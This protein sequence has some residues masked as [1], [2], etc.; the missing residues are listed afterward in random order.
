MRDETPAHGIPSLTKVRASRISGLSATS[1]FPSENAVTAN[2]T[3]TDVSAGVCRN[4]GES[5]SF[6]GLSTLAAACR[7]CALCSSG[8]IAFAVRTNPAAARKAVLE[9]NSRLF[10]ASPSLGLK[11]AD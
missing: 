1:T 3:P 2:A 5:S 11:H 6:A 8:S 7:S 4:G 10:I 9:I